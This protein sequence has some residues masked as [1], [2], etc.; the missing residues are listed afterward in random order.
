MK[1]TLITLITMLMAGVA[2]A[3]TGLTLFTN[4]GSGHHYQ[5]DQTGAIYFDNDMIEIR[6]NLNNG[7]LDQYQI[8]DVNKIVFDA[9]LGVADNRAEQILIY[10]NPAS[11]N[12]SIRGLQAQR[13]IKIIDMMGR[14]IIDQEA[15]DGQTIDISSL[16]PGVYMVK[17]DAT[18][19]R[20]I[21][22]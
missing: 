19:I 2:M 4:D 12:I 6:E 14:T 1:K 15:T 8:S 3:Q 16:T 13:Q 10:P 5:V 20:F 7:A 22:Q 9:P 11:Q 18:F 21:K 17:A